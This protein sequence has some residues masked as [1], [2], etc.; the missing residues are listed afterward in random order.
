M[1][2]QEIRTDLLKWQVRIASLGLRAFSRY[3]QSDR[4][5]YIEMPMKFTQ[6][7]YPPELLA[8]LESI[9]LK[10]LGSFNAT[11]DG[12]AA[13]MGLAGS[14]VTSTDISLGSSTPSTSESS[15]TTTTTTTT[16]S[17][18]SSTSSY[19]NLVSSL[20]Y[21]N[22]VTVA[23]QSTLPTALVVMRTGTWG[24]TPGEYRTVFPEDTSIGTTPAYTKL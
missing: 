16:G 21:L 4:S 6:A 20:S 19:S 12:E 23:V 24:L 1:D 7:A 9:G 8:D 15:S 5:A 2:P 22:G 3:S 17:S 14:S 13:T 18:S 10:L 11:L